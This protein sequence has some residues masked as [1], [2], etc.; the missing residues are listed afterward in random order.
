[1]KVVPID[2]NKRLF[3]VGTICN[4][5]DLKRD[6]YYKYQKRFVIKKQIE[7]DIIELVRESRR[8]LPR[9]GTRKLMRSL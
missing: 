8:T 6:A 2:R 1:M 3:S 9:E 4:A 5:F 7:Q